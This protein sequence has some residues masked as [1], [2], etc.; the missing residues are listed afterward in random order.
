MLKRRLNF[1]TKS[2]DDS[3]FQ[4]GTLEGITSCMMGVYARDAKEN[5]LKT[6]N[7]RLPTLL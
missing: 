6:I 7:D 2:S 4:A 3:D 1:K 5:D